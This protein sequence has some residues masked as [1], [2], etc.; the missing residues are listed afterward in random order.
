VL[1]ADDRIVLVDFET[2]HYGD[3]AFDLGFFLSHLLLKTVLHGDRFGEYVGL[4]KSFWRTY[5]A[6]IKELVEC[7][8]LA[9]SE[10]IR[11]TNAHLAGCMWARID[12]T[13]KVDYL[14]ES[15]QE[16]VRSFCRGLFVNPP[17]E[18][19]EVIDRLAVNLG[20]KHQ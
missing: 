1:I 17:A 2:G 9:P 16:R 11:R 18:W 7:P 4:T 3:P 6:G 13:S 14:N 12:A 20:N 5:L 8:Q 10:I 15:Q 19:R